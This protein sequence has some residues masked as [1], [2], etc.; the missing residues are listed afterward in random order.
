MTKD[1]V[2]ESFVL[3]KDVSGSLLGKHGITLKEIV[4]YNVQLL[5]KRIQEKY[6]IIN[7]FHVEYDK[8]FNEKGE[9][10]IK[11]SGIFPK[12]ERV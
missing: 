3:H 4:D 6:P 8:G 7:S 1:V 5:K 11:V 10:T 2:N 9:L 12:G